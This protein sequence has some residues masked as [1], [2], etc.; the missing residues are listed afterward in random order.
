MQ[1]PICKASVNEA[2][3][4]KEGSFFP[5]CSDRCRLIDLGRWLSGKYAIPVQR[6]SDAALPP[7][8]PEQKPKGRI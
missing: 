6:D 3:A 1:C 8:N 5:F 2:D 4:G 7:Q